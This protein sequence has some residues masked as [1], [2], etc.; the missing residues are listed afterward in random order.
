MK[1]NDVSLGAFPFDARQKFLLVDVLPV[2]GIDFFQDSHVSERLGDADGNEFLEF[3]GMRVCVVGGPE[4]CG[5]YPSEG[6]DEPLG[7]IEFK[8]NDR[9]GCLG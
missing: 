8:S 5:R 7:G 4:K 2:T 3:R 6:F 1:K 9:G